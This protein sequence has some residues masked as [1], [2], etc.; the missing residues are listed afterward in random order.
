MSTARSGLRVRPVEPGD[1]VELC[2][3]LNE[4]IAIGGTT[5]FETPMTE[6]DFRGAFAGAPGLI[7]LFVAVGEGGRLLGFQFLTRHDKL[8]DGWADI[9]TFARVGSQAAGIG[10]ALFSETL[11]LARQRGLAAI[12]ATIRA[13]NE[14]GLAYYERM[15]FVT[16]AVDR[17]VPLQSG[18]SV[19]RVSK[20]F[21]VSWPG[22]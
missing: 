2:G 8:P 9:A 1:V 6:E 21:R 14:G 13:D 7:S 18:L 19:D 10:R 12:N 15:G 17:D 4:I 20:S 22:A 16:Y 3:L 5:A 11:S